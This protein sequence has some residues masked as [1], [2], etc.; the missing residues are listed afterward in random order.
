MIASKLHTI[1]L[2]NGLRLI[3]LE[4]INGYNKA[5]TLMM[6]DTEAELQNINLQLLLANFIRDSKFFSSTLENIVLIEGGK[7][8]YGLK[9][10]Q[11]LYKMIRNLQDLFS[12][13]NS[14]CVLSGSHTCE[15]IIQE[16]YSMVWKEKGLADE[17][18][19][20]LQNQQQELKK[21]QQLIQELRKELESKELSNNKG[22]LIDL[23]QQPSFNQPGLMLGS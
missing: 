20:V 3:N 15:G 17:P 7:M 19:A 9:V 23:Y 12:D 22:I 4:R 14:Q 5:L 18:K 21:A 2:L 6:Q 1:R 16:A 8:P 10:D 11:Q 13:M